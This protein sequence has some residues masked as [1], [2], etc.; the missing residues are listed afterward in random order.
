MGASGAIY[1][2]LVG[3]SGPLLY[4]PSLLD[5][6]QMNVL[7]M[8]L[9]LATFKEDVGSPRLDGH[10]ADIARAVEAESLKAPRSPREWAALMLTVANHETHFSIR[11]S[12]GQ[13][14]KWECDR[15]LARGMWQLHAN[16]FNRA[17][18]FRQNGDIG[19]QA[20]LASAQLKR[21]YATCPQDFPRGA[22]NAFAGR[23]CGDDWPGLKARLGTFQRL[24]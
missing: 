17:E 12:D 23:R 3:Y 19:L 2:G 6:F 4:R 7:A 24:R 15:G 16:Y 1:D 5:S 13:C 8:I 22:L 18:W 14:K 10:R 20:K 21:A 9:L 11:I